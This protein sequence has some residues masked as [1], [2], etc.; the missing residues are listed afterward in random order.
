MLPAARWAPEAGRGGGGGGGSPPLLSWGGRAELGAP[1]KWATRGHT[2]LL[3][4]HHAGSL[5]RVL[6][7]A[8][9]SKK[10][11]FSRW[12]RA[13]LPTVCGCPEGGWG[14]GR[15]WSRAQGSPGSTLWPP[16]VFTLR[17]VSSTEDLTLTQEA[18]LLLIGT[19][20]NNLLKYVLSF[21][22]RM[23]ENQSG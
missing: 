8:F 2:P 13:L 17:G 22:T 4:G 11:T 15:G 20:S 9:S 23:C 6:L 7:K 12:L 14:K 5:R 3:M 16:R 10:L 21:Q 18:T 1:Q 19:V